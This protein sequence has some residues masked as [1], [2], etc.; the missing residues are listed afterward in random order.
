M[1][2]PRAG[3]SV[4]TFNS[5]GAPPAAVSLSTSS[6]VTLI[7]ELGSSSL[8]YA[9]IR[10]DGRVMAWLALD[11]TVSVAMIS[12]ESRSRNSCE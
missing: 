9:A 5:A 10:T 2:K 12:I 11:A 1:S 6:K 7:L 8:M 4:V 3:V